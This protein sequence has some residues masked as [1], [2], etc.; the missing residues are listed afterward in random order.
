MH[1]AKKTQYVTDEHGKRVAAVIDL[2]T[3]E[4]F[5]EAIEEL[6]DIREYDEAKNKIKLEVREGNA[7]TLEEYLRKRLKKKR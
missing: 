2:S 1:P 3:Y 4:K 6:E 5:V 7:V